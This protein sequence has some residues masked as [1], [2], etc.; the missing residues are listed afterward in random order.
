LKTEL[1]AL[2]NKLSDQKFSYL[3]KEIETLKETISS[4]SQNN[5]D[6]SVAI[7]AL[8]KTIDK[9]L[10]RINGTGADVL[11]GILGYRKVLVSD[12]ALMAQKVDPQ[13]SQGIIQ[14]LKKAGLVTTILQKRD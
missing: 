4:Q 7:G 13:I 3:K 9:G 8:Q 6:F 2:K 10:D 1:E 5:S 11:M 14:P 12:P